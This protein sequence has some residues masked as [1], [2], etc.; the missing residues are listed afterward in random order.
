MPPI[1]ATSASFSGPRGCCPAL[2][3]TQNTG[4]FANGDMTFAYNSDTCRQTV[5]LTCSTPDPSLD[6]NAGIVAN[7]VNFLNFT[8]TSTTFPLTCQASDM[9]WYVTEPVPLRVDTLECILA[10]P[11]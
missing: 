8:A 6:L 5:L 7:S 4:E 3:V 9:R 11:A 2:T 10:N 1:G